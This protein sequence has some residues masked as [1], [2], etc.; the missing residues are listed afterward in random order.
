MSKSIDEQTDAYYQLALCFV[1]L[2]RR[3]EAAVSAIQAVVRNPNFKAAIQL[4]AD[5]QPVVE[6][7]QRWETF[8]EGANNE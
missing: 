6:W 2:G 4:I 3:E 8:A 5:V 1:M 7:K